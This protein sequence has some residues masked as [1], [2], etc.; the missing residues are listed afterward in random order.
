MPHSRLR[1]ASTILATLVVL[2]VSAF[3]LKAQEEYRPNFLFDIAVCESA[4][5]LLSIIAIQQDGDEERSLYVANQAFADG[6]CAA[7]PVIKYQPESVVQKWDDDGTGEPGV[8]LAG[9]LIYPNGEREPG[10][11]WIDQSF[12]K[13]HFAVDD[14][15]A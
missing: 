14:P 11:V 1:Q 6:E 8:V 7:Y 3:G 4:K 10:F 9:W 13:D 5:P 12:L 15:E 2:G